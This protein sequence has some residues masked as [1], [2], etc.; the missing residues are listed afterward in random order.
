MILAVI[1]DHS[2]KSS[3]VE[4][5]LQSLAAVCLRQPENAKQVLEAD[6][7]NLIISTMSK[8]PKNT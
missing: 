5:G 1:E 8:H 7:A 6:G 3:T 4:N 2:M